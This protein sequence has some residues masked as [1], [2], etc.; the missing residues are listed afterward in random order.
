MPSTPTESG[1]STGNVAD[2]TISFSNA[3]LTSLND[4]AFSAFFEEV[5]DTEGVSFELNG[6]ADIVARTSIG[7]V[8]IGGVSVVIAAYQSTSDR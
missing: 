2:L 3:T 5:T 7:D 1:V 6:A 8:P 4:D